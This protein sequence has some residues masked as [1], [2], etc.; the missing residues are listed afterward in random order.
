MET[1]VE[2]AD[3]SPP[4][5]PRY[6]K[7]DEELLEKVNSQEVTEMTLRD[8]LTQHVEQVDY[9]MALEYAMQSGVSEELREA[10]YLNSLEGSY[11]FVDFQSPVFVFRFIP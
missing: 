3:E 4:K 9:E 8:C 6:D 5:R 7:E 10:I 1:L 11:K 2:I